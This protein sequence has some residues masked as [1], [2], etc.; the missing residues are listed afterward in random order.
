MR[1][2]LP[3][4]DLDDSEGK[5]RGNSKLETERMCGVI[6]EPVSGE[7][8]LVVENGRISQERQIEAADQCHDRAGPNQMRESREDTQIH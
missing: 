6:Q 7:E 5:I 8:K 2:H 4:E 3:R 1:L